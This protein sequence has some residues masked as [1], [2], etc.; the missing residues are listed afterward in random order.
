MPA[1]TLERL[2]TQ[3]ETSRY[4]FG[5]GEDNQIVKLL[6]RLDAAHL[7][8]PTQL[9]RFH[10]ALLF[11]RAFPQSPRVVSLTERILKNF[12]KKVEALRRSTTNMEEFD[13]FATSGIAG[14]QM[15]D[16]LSF[17][18]ARWL[19]RRLPGQVEVAWDNYDPGREFCNTGPR[20]L[21]LL[22]DDANVEADT[23]WRRWLEEAAG[24]KT[25]TKTAA[26]LIERF[27]NLPLPPQ[28][29]S[30]LYDSLRVP[31]RWS[32]NNSPITRT[33]NWK[34]VRSIFY[35][36][37]PLISRSQVS[38]ADELAKRPPKLTKLSRRQGEEIIELIREVMLVRY[39][40]LYGT[41]LGD[42]QSVIRADVGRG[43][44]IYLWNLPPDRRL[45][46]RAYTAG[47]TLKNGVPINYIEAIGLCECMEV[48]FNTFYT[49]RGGEAGWIYAQV[50]R[51]LCHQMGTTCVSVYP[52]QLG[53]ENEEAIDSGAFWFYRKLG[54]RPGRPELQKLAEREEQKIAAS[55][56]YRTPKR[57][58][59]RLAAGHVFYE[60][61]GSEVGAWDKFSTRNI[62]L[63]ITRLMARDF[64]G[65]AAR[66]RE[67]SRRE[68]ERIL[69]VN[70]SSWALLDKSAFENFALVLAQA[71]SLRSWTGQEKEDLLRIIRAK[72]KPDEMLYLHQMQ[73]H[74]R[75]REAMQKLASP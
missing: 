43:V 18:V 20:F 50:L 23:P 4:Q 73:R 70:T 44:S 14:T 41:T 55:P 30:E 28:Q 67:H 11:L 1:T 8:D 71:P 7:G 37:E 40:E 22:E 66:M 6:K 38:L 29:K 9:I 32:L 17:D 34:P 5:P 2:L 21:P 26:W 53:H 48:G 16:T 3:L 61:P 35:H 36:T 24:K 64:G 58:L 63:Q 47:L 62:G 57:T 45:P 15:E 49:F 60:L 46:L 74:G 51:C 72:A 39:R 12:H 59:K 25:K 10:E 56:K 54:F 33:R 69:G 68:L 31:L 27:E 65:A 19:V 75:L 13:S 42:P 52:Y